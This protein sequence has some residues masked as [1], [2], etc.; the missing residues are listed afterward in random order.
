[1]VPKIDATLDDLIKRLVKLMEK[2]APLTTK[3][4]NDLKAPTFA[5][6]K[7]RKMPLDTCN[8]VR[9][10]MSRFNQV[11]GVSDAERRT[12]YRKIIRAANK[13]GIDST[14][15]KDKYSKKYG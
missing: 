11:Q 1:M 5:F 6:P 14:G 13:C 10:A 4:R 8:R 3:K 12:A 7:Q 2:A 9:A 15:F